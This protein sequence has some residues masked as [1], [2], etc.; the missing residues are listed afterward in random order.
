MQLLHECRENGIDHFALRRNRRRHQVPLAF[1]SMNSST[2]LSDD[3][4]EI[5]QSE[6]LAHLES[7]SSCQSLKVAFSNTISLLMKKRKFS[8]TMT[9]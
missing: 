7:I 8:I 4:G 3:F 5:D 9:L 6:I 1:S 2:E